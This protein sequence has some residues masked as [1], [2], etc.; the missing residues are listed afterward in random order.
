VFSINEFLEI[1]Q[2]LNNVNKS[3][4]DNIL[5]ILKILTEQNNFTNILMN[6]DTKYEDLCNN[7][8]NL[9]NFLNS[10]LGETEDFPKLILNIFV[11]EIKK[12]DNDNYQK[13]LVEII[14]GN[15]NLIS[16]SY[17]FISLIL[18]NL[19]DITPGSISENL[20][21]LQKNN[22]LYLEPISASN[23]DVLNEIILSTFENHFN[24]YFESIPEL[25]DDD[26][27]EYFPK[28]SESIDNP[29]L[30]LSDK[31]L[32]V[33]KNCL[34]FLEMIYN[35][36]IEKRNEII[37]NEL[38]CKLYCIAYVKIYLFK[39]IQFNHYNNQEFLEFN[40]I[41]KV[42]EGNAKNNF[43]KMIKI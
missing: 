10:N 6:D 35:N 5:N 37:D 7:I 32:E 14:L 15:P 41:V 3:N 26:L 31:S 38:L 24:L 1:E 27:K 20:A 25:L 11:D 12:I 4:I 9:Y 16:I 33:F 22:N 13:K 42:I 17:P 2:K 40:E 19:I 29:T 18:K 34:N 39:S 36:K 30:I 43:R 21:N 28:Y 8:Q 23:N